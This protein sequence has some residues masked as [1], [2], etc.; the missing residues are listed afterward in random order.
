MAGAVSHGTDARTVLVSHA[1]GLARDVELARRLVVRLQP[2]EQYRMTTRLETSLEQLAVSASS[3]LD[4]A[5][6]SSA[7]D[8]WADVHAL[9]HDVDALLGECLVLVHGLAER[10]VDVD[11]GVCAVADALADELV[12]RTPLGHW[13]TMT[14]LGRSEQYARATRVVQVRFPAPTVWD[15]P[16]VAHELGHF[17][18]PALSLSAGRR[19]SHPLEDVW[20]KLGDGTEQSWSWLQ[21]LFADA[22]AA[23][24]LGPAYGFACVAV[25]FDPLLALVATSTHPPA[26]QR[27]QLVADVLSATGDRRSAFAAEQVRQ[28]WA[29]LVE[30]ADGTAGREPVGDP[31]FTGALVELLQEQ[32][33]VSQWAD[34]QAAHAAAERL[35]EPAV[36]PD[37]PPT[38]SLATVLNGAW[39]ARRRS[40]SDAMTSDIAAHAL[41]WCLSLSGRTS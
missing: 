28:W 35:T 3:L 14:V 38:D 12:A 33:P 41:T 27:V 6:S 7:P 29:A 31:Q 20:T 23:H 30:A 19:T 1:R 18:G 8:V 25:A 4:L 32:L 22:F 26:D 39:Q 5:D 10:E 21:E 24:V 37:R 13:D 17:V 16:V 36:Q 2:R 15:L 34:W 40:S 9:R 11:E